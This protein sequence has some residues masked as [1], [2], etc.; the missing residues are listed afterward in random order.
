MPEQQFEGLSSHGNIQE[1]LL[2]AITFAKET[3]TTDFVEWEVEKIYGENGGFVQTNV[4]KV[5]IKAKPFTKPS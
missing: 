1:A 5:V 2:Q 3:M 4:I